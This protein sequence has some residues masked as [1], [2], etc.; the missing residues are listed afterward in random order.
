[1]LDYIIAIEIPNSLSSLTVAKLFNVSPAV[2][3]IACREACMWAVEQDK[4]F[5]F[6]WLF[7][8]SN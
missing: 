6:H 1:M 4:L 3:L 5:K 8:L 7:G 2:G